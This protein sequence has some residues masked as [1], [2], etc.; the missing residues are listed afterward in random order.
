[1]EQKEYLRSLINELLKLPKECEWVEFKHNNS[2]K[3][4][5]GTYISCLSNSATLVGK[6][7]AYVVWGIDD[8]SHDILGTSFNP[9][10][11]KIG[12]EKL[13]SLLRQLWI[14]EERGSGIDKV[15]LAIEA[16]QLPAPLFEAPGYFTRA[17]LFSKRELKNLTKQDQIRACYFHA[18][19]KYIERDYMTN[20]SLRERFGIEAKNVAM[21]SR[22]INDALKSGLICIY[23]ES[24][25]AKARKYIPTWARN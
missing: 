14:C 17:V 24:V 12:N 4:D 11:Q 18:S 6:S 15:V 9:F 10:S 1:M 2:N 13:A 25:G 7:F 3:E 22:I 20:T 16:N 23:D 5:I 8:A 19:L 21:T